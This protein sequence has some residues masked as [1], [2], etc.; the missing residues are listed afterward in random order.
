MRYCVCLEA[1]WLTIG[2]EAKILSLV[3]PA[4]WQSSWQFRRTAV[5]QRKIHQGQTQYEHGEIAHSTAVR[6][7]AHDTRR[8]P[9]A[10]WKACS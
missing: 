1:A 2:T 4:E 8:T 5:E 7:L 10:N 9:F 6:T 3:W